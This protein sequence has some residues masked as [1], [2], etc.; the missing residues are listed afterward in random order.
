MACSTVSRKLVVPTS[1]SCGY[2]P[3]L[4]LGLEEDKSFSYNPHADS[5]PEGDKSSGY[6]PLLDSGLEED[7]HCVHNPSQ[8]LG[9]RMGLGSS[10]DLN[11][12]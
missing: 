1:K 12:R 11:D 5:G 6:N 4:D 8:V 10:S 9:T 2:N 3:L 7:K